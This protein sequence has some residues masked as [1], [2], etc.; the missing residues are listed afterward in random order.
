MPTGEVTVS[1]SL[2]WT[3]TWPSPRVHLELLGPRA[4][5]GFLCSQ[6]TSSVSLVMCVQLFKGKFFKEAGHQEYHYKSDCV[7]G[8]L[9]WVRHKYNFDNLG[10]VSPRL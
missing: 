8:Q 3:S 6:L 1:V 10:Q 7:G 4:G 2:T 9:P 5:L